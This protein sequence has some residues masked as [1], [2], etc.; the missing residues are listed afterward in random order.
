[1]E[2][3]K[4]GR[5]ISGSEAVD[6]ADPTC[7]TEDASVNKE[8]PVEMFPVVVFMALALEVSLFKISDD[9]SKI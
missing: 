2:N 8:L 5:G 4:F 9:K 3:R 6:P 7:K 1:M